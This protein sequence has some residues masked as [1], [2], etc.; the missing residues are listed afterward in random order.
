MVTRVPKHVGC[1]LRS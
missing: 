1:I